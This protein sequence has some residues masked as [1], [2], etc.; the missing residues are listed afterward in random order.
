VLVLGAKSDVWSCYAAA[1]DKDNLNDDDPLG[2]DEEDE[3]EGSEEED[4]DDSADGNKSDSDEEEGGRLLKATLEARQAARAAGDHPLQQSFRAAAAELLEKYGTAA[5]TKKKNSKKAKLADSPQEEAELA[6]EAAASEDR[7]Q[8]AEDSEEGSILATSEAEEDSADQ[9]ASSADSGSDHTSAS[10]QSGLSEP[11]GSE[12]ES[13]SDSPAATAEQASQQ[14]SERQKAHAEAQGSGHAH[15]VI[16][17]ETDDIPFTIA[18]PSS[19]AAFA[20]L[21]QGHSPGKL[22][23]IVQRIRACNAIA[24][25][26]D[27]RRK[28]Q[29]G[30]CTTFSCWVH[31]HERCL[32]YV[33]VVSSSLSVCR[34]GA[35][36]S[37]WSFGA[38]HQLT[39]PLSIQNWSNLASSLCLLHSIC[40]WCCQTCSTASPEL[41]N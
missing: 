33:T 17:E 32:L 27:N 9:E 12:S 4:S 29:A 39:G 3:E 25:A 41:F 22:S 35:V 37:N 8:A 6:A 24:L 18:A 31:A 30:F 15:D 26:T 10:A 20:Q 38:A 16:P 7:G 40:C 23:L 14:S 5:E 11:A 2:S 36:Y 1:A 28:L 19:Y 21:V 34:S 13:D